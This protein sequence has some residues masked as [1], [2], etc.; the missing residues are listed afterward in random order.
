MTA[1]LAGRRVLVVGGAG[2]VGSNLVRRL[3]ARHADIVV[4][5]NLLSSDRSD[6]L[7]SKG[8]RFLQG[9]I[10]DDVIL[11]QVDDTF[12]FI[13]HLATFHG[14]QNSIADPLADHANN[15]LTTLKLFEH[16]KN[17][18]HLRSITYASAGCTVAEKTYQG[19]RATT[20]DDPVSL[21]LDSPYQIS[22]ILGEMYANFYHARFGVPA[23]I[24][25]FQNVYGPWEILGAGQWRGT[26]ATVWRNVVPTF[27]YRAIKGMPLCLENAGDSTRDF[28]YVDDVVRGLIACATVG[29]AGEVYNIASG[30]EVSIKELAETV[31]SAVGG[32]VH[33]EVAE[34]R[35]WD[36]SGQR[37]GSTE[38]AREAL[39]FV[40]EMDITEGIRRT[41]AWTRANLTLVDQAIERHRE[42]LAA[43]A[44]A[45]T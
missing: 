3:A 38:K 34:R 21:H 10:A 13:F 17:F 24:A 20:E 36:R 33:L 2:F 7:G 5:D 28:V 4:V 8:V 31:V 42:H 27:V 25:R 32:D 22:K 44:G 12:D 45:R 15:A 39:G 9:S 14:N 6:V 26:S 29:Q 11:A 37:H 41:V 43:N 30:T 16:V 23:V 40:T 35:D 1:V 18:R 19:A